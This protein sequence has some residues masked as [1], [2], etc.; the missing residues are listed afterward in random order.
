MDPA[1]LALLVRS[2]QVQPWVAQ[3]CDVQR[4]VA[5]SPAR[6]KAVTTSR[7]GGKTVELVAECADKLMRCRRG[8]VVLYVAK[9]RDTAKELAWDKFSALSEQ[10][11][12][13][14]VFKVGDLR[15]ET[16]EGGAL[17]LRGAEGSDAEKERQKMR[18]LKVRHCAI[19]EAQAIAGTL[20]RLLRETIEPALGD[21]RGSCTVAGTPG[22]VMGGGWYNISHD[23]EGCEEKWTRF[24]WT[25][26]ENTFFRDAEEYLAAA[27][28]EN[29]WT[30]ETPTYRRE[31]EGKWCA[32]PSVQVYRYLAA[33]NDVIGFIPGYDLSWP[34]SLGVDFGQDDAC[35]W[36]LHTN[37]P[38]TREVYGVL[39]FK[40]R[41]LSPAECGAITGW[42]VEKT[43]PDV[44]VG[45]G[46][47]LGGN[48]YIDAIN[49]R[50]SEVTRQRMESAQK[51]EKRAYID[52]LNGDLTSGRL[53]FLKGR[54]PWVGDD[55]PEAIRDAAKYGCE[56]LCDELE[57]L[58]WANEARLKEHGGHANHCCDSN[59]YSWRHFSTYLDEARPAEREPVPGEPAYDAWL[60]DQDAQQARLEH[61][62]PWWER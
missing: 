16:P 31:Y 49:E 60:M 43:T 28:R 33:R 25:V 52:F 18:G 26:R 50:L 11:K 37:R 59:L 22:E 6:W 55:A 58:P 34:H 12:L 35:A 53:R 39:S 13:P 61:E 62:T 48:V 41:G 56:P 44:L 1:R 3:L 23:H 19:D 8:E 32:D 40:L 2:V 38:G 5:L 9:T 30:V 4:A 15:I 7:R 36:T 21:L 14:W 10:F 57:T 17:L 24:E 42:L 27:L 51:T 46:G 47:N 29:G 45:D 20:R 54:V